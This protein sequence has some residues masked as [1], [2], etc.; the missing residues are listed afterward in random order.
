[1]GVGWRGRPRGAGGAELA[2]EIPTITRELVVVIQGLVILFSGALEHMFRPQLERLF[3]RR[4][5]DLPAEA[6]A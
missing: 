1:M 6:E 4:G 5:A 2:F 3:Q